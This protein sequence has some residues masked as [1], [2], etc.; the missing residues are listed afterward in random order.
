MGEYR[1]GKPKKQGEYLP[2]RKPPQKAEEPK[3]K[4]LTQPLFRS[5]KE[6]E[7]KGPWILISAPMA[8]SDLLW[9]NPRGVYSVIGY[10]PSQKEAIERG[11]DWYNKNSGQ[12]FWV[13]ETKDFHGEA[14]WRGSSE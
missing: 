4:P 9:N 1:V 5:K 8:Y 2:T 12:L 10:Y 13:T 3:R 11:W 14:K 7:E 6:P